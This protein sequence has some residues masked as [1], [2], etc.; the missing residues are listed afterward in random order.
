MAQPPHLLL[1]PAPPPLP[2]RR[3]VTILPAALSPHSLA[4]L[5]SNV[6]F[7]G[8]SFTFSVPRNADGSSSAYDS[9]SA[10]L[11]TDLEEG[12]YSPSESEASE[13]EADSRDVSQHGP[14]GRGGGAGAQPP[15]PP[16]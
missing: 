2:L 14:G 9:G 6:T 1:G 3:S 11:G 10:L 15:R 7:G 16:E 13:S 12:P 4:S 8:A 5:P